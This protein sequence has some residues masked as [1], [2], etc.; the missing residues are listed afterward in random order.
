VIPLLLPEQIEEMVRFAESPDRWVESPPIFFPSTIIHHG[1]DVGYAI[2]CS[3]KRPSNHKAVGPLPMRHLF[4]D[5]TMME[6]SVG[7]VHFVE[8]TIKAFK[9]DEDSILKSESNCLH[10]LQ[11]LFYGL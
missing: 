9:M 4:I 1:V 5:Y 7:L 3:I 11:K 2:R 10:V 8:S 6:E